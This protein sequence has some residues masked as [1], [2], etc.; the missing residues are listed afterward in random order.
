[1]Y[2]KVYYSFFLSYTTSRRLHTFR[3]RSNRNLASRV[4]FR[5]HQLPF[6]ILLLTHCQSVSVPLYKTTVSAA[7]RKD[8]TAKNKSTNQWI[9]GWRSSC[10][11]TA[12]SASAHDNELLHHN[13]VA[14]GQFMYPDLVDWA[15]GLPVS[16]LRVTHPWQLTVH[17]VT[18]P[19]E[20]SGLLIATGGIL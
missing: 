19:A 5:L 11:L 8:A 17:D 9:L 10:S 20:R 6:L 4:A 15:Q 12:A 14:G 13:L 3:S 2:K 16:R 7:V 1:M 18:V